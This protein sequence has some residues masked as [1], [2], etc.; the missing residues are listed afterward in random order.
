M[1]C[2]FFQA[3]DGIRNRFTWLEFRRVLFRSPHWHYKRSSVS[4]TVYTISQIF[5]C[6][7]LTKGGLWVYKLA[8]VPWN[9][10]YLRF[11]KVLRFNILDIYISIRL[12]FMNRFSLSVFWYYQYWCFDIGLNKSLLD[13]NYYAITRIFW[14]RVFEYSI[15]WFI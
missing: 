14:Y 9:L 12:I 3:E 13:G 5:T 8:L 2:F 7:A 15:V 4:E 10:K 6:T 1:L 11:D